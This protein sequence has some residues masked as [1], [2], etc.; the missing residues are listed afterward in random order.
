MDTE[1]AKHLSDLN[2]SLGRIDER[3]VAIHDAQ[4]DM[5]DGM[6]DHED[7]NRE[8]FKIVHGRV[9]RVEKK[10]SWMLGIGSALMGVVVFASGLIAKIFGGG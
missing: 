9:S 5:A 10:Q 1:L 6:K 8:D 2:E 7:R 3:C 4:R